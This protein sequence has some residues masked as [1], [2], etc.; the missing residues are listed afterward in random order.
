MRSTVRQ[1]LYARLELDEATGCL[2]WTGYV[3]KSGYAQIGVNGRQRLIHRVAWE[4]DNG[5]I[6][7]GLVID[8]VY[9]RG[10]RYRHCANVVHLEPV[11][12]ALNIRRMD[13]ANNGRRRTPPPD[14]P[15][16]QPDVLS[17]EFLREFAEWAGPEE[18]AD[19]H[20]KGQA[21]A[22]ALASSP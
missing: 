14:A 22:L 19:L 7:D 3:G 15:G 11:T 17:D 9:E 8:H 1:R 18:W 16:L 10:C 13:I 6:P 4:L 12:Q 20:P 5:P 21:R 2:L